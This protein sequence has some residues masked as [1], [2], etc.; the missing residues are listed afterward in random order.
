FDCD[1]F[2]GFSFFHLHGFNWSRL[3]KTRHNRSRSRTYGPR[4]QKNLKSVKALA[5]K[6]LT[7][8]SQGRYLGS[9]KS[10][11]TVTCQFQISLQAL[12][13][14]LNQA[15]PYFIRCIKSNASKE[16]N[17]FDNE[18]V[19]RQLRYTGM[20]ETVRIRQ[21]G[22]NVRMM[23]DE[24]IQHYRILLPHGLLSS[25]S[26]VKQFLRL[27]Q[28]DRSEYQ[29]GK[30]KIFMRESQKQ[31]LDSLLHQTIL[32]RIILIQ[33]WYRSK[34]QRRNFIILRNSVIKIQ[35]QVRCWISQQIANNLRI[36]HHAA[37]C[38][39][40][41]WKGYKTRQWYKSLRHILIRIQPVYVKLSDCREE[42]SNAKVEP[43]QSH[44]I[45]TYSQ[46]A[47][48]GGGHKEKEQQTAPPRRKS[49]AA[50][51][52]VPV[53]GLLNN[54]CEDTVKR[55]S[56]SDT[57]TFPQ[58]SPNANLRRCS[59][60]ALSQIRR[61]PPLKQRRSDET[62]SGYTPPLSPAPSKSEK[63]D[64][65]GTKPV[66][67]RS[68][69]HRPYQKVPADGVEIKH[70]VDHERTSYNLS[71]E[72]T[73]SSSA[74]K[75]PKIK[76]HFKSFI[77]KREG[78]VS[79]SDDNSN[80]SSGPHTPTSSTA[81]E[82]VALI[83]QDN[84][85]NASS[86]K[87][88]P[89]LEVGV[90][91]S[92]KENT[93]YTRQI[94]NEKKHSSG[95]C[96]KLFHSACLRSSF[97]VSCLFINGPAGKENS[98]PAMKKVRRHEE[99]NWNLTGTSQFIDRSDEVI[100]DTSELKALEEFITR[101][102]YSLENKF[103]ERFDPVSQ[104]LAA[105][106]EPNS[107]ALRERKDSQVDQLF[108]KSLKAFK[109]YLVSAYSV[110]SQNETTEVVVILKY[111]DLIKH[112]E[113]EMST[114]ICKES[115]GESAFPITMGV[116][117]FRGFLDEF[118]RDKPKRQEDKVVKKRRRPRRK[119]KDKKAEEIHFGTHNF[120]H[121][122]VN[123]YT[124]CEVCNSILWLSTKALSCQK[125]KVTC[126]QKC[127]NKVEPACS[128][129]SS[130][131]A[132]VVGL[133][134][135][136]KGGSKIPHVRPVRRG[137]IFGVPLEN[138]VGEDDKIP[139]VV[140]KIM[141]SL[142]FHGLYTEG[143]YRKSGASSKVREIKGQIDEDP[144]SVTFE[145]APIHVLTA[146]FK[147]YLRE[148]PEPLM[149]FDAYDSLLHASSLEDHNEMFQTALSI[150][151]RLPKPNFYLLERLVFHLALV[152]LYEGYNRMNSSS[153]AILQAL[154]N[155]SVGGTSDTGDG[156]H[157][158]KMDPRDALALYKLEEQLSE[159]EERKCRLTLGL[160]ELVRGSSEEELLSTDMSHAGSL[161]DVTSSVSTGYGATASRSVTST[162]S[163][164]LEDV[165]SDLAPVRR[166]R[167]SVKSNSESDDKSVTSSRFQQE[168][169]ED[170]VMVENSLG[171]DF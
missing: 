13:E 50:L 48:V 128:Q 72:E 41:T 168:L 80:D 5:Q 101:K 85:S 71:E 8:T 166:K 26:D 78:S 34:L 164:S 83:P 61:H 108:C 53:D 98:S 137:K 99:G 12:M 116:N 114:L 96:K 49:G 68:F 15:N 92:K 36:Q 45:S 58:E 158:P 39:Q 21:A 163:L 113:K 64:L 40:R 152:A 2:Y 77:S 146:I 133:E 118:I 130:T 82:T 6:T 149:T 87:S 104:S 170:T 94:S 129:N 151:N 56:S 70:D 52:R 154:Y 111:K 44:S 29:I 159:C 27:L 127:L 126:H 161:E 79:E 20:L 97:S 57:N 14:A 122:F 42:T 46:S 30:T 112:F 169:T 143:L 106:L 144:E 140:E 91:P 167:R 86:L 28:L 156:Y 35:S 54:V 150:I 23:F 51:R 7:L 63:N 100:K 17:M 138:L 107:L 165:E 171:K 95:T 55:R 124:Q 88:F 18:L 69:R 120:I 134:G 162:P 109:C 67:A 73:L 1:P 33:R 81:E 136:R 148:L 25:Q 103:E 22:F 139:S 65:E 142:E 60:T 90:R 131:K 11:H 62:L 10:P 16:P 9:R 3:K 121:I 123:I 157:A 38:I 115:D 135:S 84:I 110:A 31:K 153:L 89:P 74:V 147:T 37:I 66:K 145:D 119:K 155:S 47:R 105:E 43:I 75:F 19:Q 59:E 141:A 93:K 32:S 24:F 125:C 76:R 132:V 102:I 117:A 160:T 4:N